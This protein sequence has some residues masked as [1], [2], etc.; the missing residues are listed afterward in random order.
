VAPV[1]ER[2]D[3]GRARVAPARGD[4][5]ARHAALVGAGI[6]LSRILGLVRQRVFAR[7]FG[8]R[9]DAADAF[10]AAFKI[11]NLLQNL[12]GE[13]ALS[14]SF[15]PAYASL[16]ADGDEVEAGRLAGAVFAVLAVVVSV[17]VLVGV[18]ATPLLIDLIA[19]GFK[20]EKRELAILIVRV[21]FPGAGLLVLSARCLGI[22]NSHRKFFLSYAA[23]VLWN[24]AMIAT[25]LVFGWRS[26]ESTLAVRLAWGSVVGSALQFLVQVPSVLSLARR[27]RVRWDTTSAHMR[28]VIHNFVPA[29]VGRGVVQISAYVDNWIASWLPTGAVT[30][31]TFAQ[32]LTTLPVSLFGM[33]ISAAEL[34]AMSSVR[35]SVEE[36]AG[37]L[38]SRLDA[39]LRRIAYFIVPSAVAFLALGDVVAA[40]LFQNG[41]FGRSGSEYVWGIIAGS[42]V[43]LLASTMGRLYSSTFYALRDTRTPLRFAVLRVLLTTALG[44]VFAFPLPRWLGIDRSW[45]AAG[46]TASAG[47]AGWLE[48]ALLKRALDRRIGRTGLA[49]SY[50]ARL[51]AAAAVSA[52]AAWGVKLLV[53][54]DRPLLDAP[55]IL[56]AFGGVYLGLTAATIAESRVMTRQLLRR[57]GIG[58][59]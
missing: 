17:I 45:G 13:G 29:F 27:L 25:L 19:A 49:A 18:A 1:V 38:R 20:G 40:L 53:G 37:M 32:T 3:D 15:I 35:G 44:L 10:N 7:Y 24:A 52:A 56:L 58:R 5:G 59:R 42:A 43:G 39:G 54:V 9:S 31:L 51:W 41:K 23:P 22:L 26:G 28:E 34:P 11:P 57:L 50:T 2:A 48:F 30:G 33:A 12:F 16:L 46:L 4:G 55:L 36:V 6:L 14:A 47:I 21:L 8:I